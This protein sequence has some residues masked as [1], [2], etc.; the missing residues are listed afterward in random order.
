MRV[1]ELAHSH[2]VAQGRVEGL[3]SPALFGI[4]DVF[5]NDPPVFKLED[6]M[7]QHF[8]GVAET[9]EYKPTLLSA[10]YCRRARINAND[11]RW[12][13]ILMGETFPVCNRE[14]LNISTRQDRPRS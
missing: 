2:G 14:W 13:T 8:I 3:V 12:A 1:D 9:V 10:S 6:I 7:S 11:R 4:E 5:A